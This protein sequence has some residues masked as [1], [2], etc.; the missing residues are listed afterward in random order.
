MNDANAPEK[1]SFQ[2]FIRPAFLFLVALA[3]HLA[4]YFP[5]WVEK[6]YS[7]G[8]YPGLANTLRIITRWV[9]FSLGDVLYIWFMLWL[10]IRLVQLIVR[11]V[12][13]QFLRHHIIP[14]VLRI[15]SGLLFFYIVFRLMWGLNYDRLGIA[16]QLKLLPKPYD[17]TQLARLTNLL[18]DSMNSSRGRLGSDTSLPVLST[19]SIYRFASRGYANASYQYPFLNYANRSV[20]Q[21]LFTPLAHHLGFTGYYNPFTGEAQVR[22]DIPSLVMPY[23]LCHEMA[24]QLGYA[25][26]SEANFVGY[27][28]AMQSESDFFRYS[29]MIELVNYAQ[30]EQI[31]QYVELGDT[32]SL[33]KVLQS[34]RERMDTLVRRDR[35]IIREFFEDRRSNIAPSITNLYDQYLR[36]NNQSSGVRSY[37]EVIGWVINL[38]MSQFPN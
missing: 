15:F 13:K 16:Y 11:L 8:I 23:V 33:R 5:A 36:L 12:R 14:F 22:S 24:H 10:F 34:N 28:A 25:S 1:L 27:I 26:E 38:K 37:D 35:R 29:T 3:L 20:K 9:P 21:S 30:R 32:T 19:D 31:F 17:T 6:W 7:T 2:L 4:G 18:I